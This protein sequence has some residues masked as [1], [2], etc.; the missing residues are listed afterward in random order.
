MEQWKTCMRAGNQCFEAQQYDGALTHYQA[1]C[2]RALQLFTLWFDRQQ[3]VAALVVSYHNLADLWLAM[4]NPE[5]AEQQLRRCYDYL[6]STASSAQSLTEIDEAL[7]QGLRRSYSRLLSH[8]RLYG[9]QLPSMPDPSQLPLLV[10]T[11]TQQRENH[12]DLHN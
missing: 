4:G 7:M 1:G 2:E 8:I 5:E 10:I 11:E 9:S 12:N 6:F 3:A